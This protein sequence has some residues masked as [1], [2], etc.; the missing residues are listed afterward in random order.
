MRSMVKGVRG[1][2]PRVDAPTTA[3][4]MQRGPPSPYRGAG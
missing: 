2:I 1:G 3:L 4:L